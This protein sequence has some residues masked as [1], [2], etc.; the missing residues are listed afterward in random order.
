MKDERLGWQKQV[1][2]AYDPGNS[3]ASSG[4]LGVGAAVHLRCSLQS[5][6]DGVSAESKDRSKSGYAVMLP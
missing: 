3:W 5:G 6:H 4:G 1:G 2:V